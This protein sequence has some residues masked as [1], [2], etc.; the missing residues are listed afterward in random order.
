MKIISDVFGIVGVL[1]TV[2]LYQQKNRKSLLVYKLIID[3]VWLGHYAFIGAYSGAVVCVIAALRELIF[4]K[5]DQRSKKGIIWLPIFIIVA[6]VSTVFTWNNVFSILTCIASCIA[7]VSF[8]IG[9]PRLS[10]IFVF[11]ISTCML[12]YDIACGSVAGIVNECFAVSSSAVGILLHDRK[13]K[14]T[15]ESL[16]D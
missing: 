4:V 1:L 14:S 2:I 7:V 15:P 9:K 6:I 13:N 12:V 8:F 11:P 5:R 10:R 16:N 3:V